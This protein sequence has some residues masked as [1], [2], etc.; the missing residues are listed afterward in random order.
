MDEEE[1]GGQGEGAGA[2]R[3]EG[4]ARRLVCPV[5]CLVLPWYRM[6]ALNL[7]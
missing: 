5:A 6:N 7:H 4:G 1:R 2:G 3:I